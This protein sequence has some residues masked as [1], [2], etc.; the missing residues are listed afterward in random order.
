[1][2]EVLD[3]LRVDGSQR[4]SSATT[5]DELDALRVSLLGRKGEVTLL[6]RG[7]KDVPAEQRPAMGAELN[8]LKLNLSSLLEDRASEFAGSVQVAAG[9][10]LDLTLPAPAEPSLGV[11]HPLTSVLESICDIFY[12]MGF[13]RGEGPE[14]E[15]DYYNFTALNFPDDHPARDIQDTFYIND[16]VCLRTQTS[17]VQ[18]RTMEKQ[19]PPLACIFPGR[20]YRNENADAS[21]SSEFYQIEGLVVDTDI[22]MADLKSTVDTFVQL[23]F[24]AKEPTRFRPH[25]FPFTEPSVEVDMQCV[26]CGGEG[27][28]VCGQTGWLEIMGA[29]MVHPNVFRAAGYPDDTYTGFAF[30]MGIDRIAMLKYG[31][32]DIRLLYENDMRFLQQFRGVQ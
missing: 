12:G 24:G 32:D 20:V 23:F 2:K 1:M 29:G 27:C 30:G 31:I 26:A 9:D 6:L 3:R 10:R 17:P 28:G 25:F 7:L 18:V 11:V 16:Q 13:S 19:P 8:R 22:S 15:L 14:V 5:L 4:I 21:H